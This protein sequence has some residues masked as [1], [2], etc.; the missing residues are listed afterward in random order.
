[1]T[2]APPVARISQWLKRERLIVLVPALF[3]SLYLV[4]LR[5][6]F[7]QDGWLALVA[8][9]EVAERGLPD[10]ERLTAYA[11]GARWVDQQWLAQLCMYELHSL[12]GMPLL[13]LTHVALATAVSAIA[14]TV[15]R[16]S[17]A[18][19]GMVLAVALVAFVPLSFVLATVRTQIFG[20]VA[21]AVVLALLVR[22]ARRPSGRVWAVLP[23]LAVWTNL[24]GSVL[25]GAALVGL[26]GLTIAASDR[27]HVRR[28]VGL[29][30]GAVVALLASPY[31]L[32]L[33]AYYRHTA[34]NPLFAKFVAEWG[35]ATP[36]LSTAPFYVVLLTCAWAYGRRPGALTAYEWL[37]LAV[38]GAAGM[39]TV[40]NAGW[41]ALAAIMILPTVFRA[42][43]R[44]GRAGA[45]LLVVVIPVTLF[46]VLAVIAVLRM[47]DWV[48]AAYPSGPARA[49]ERIALHDG[50]ARVFADVRFA[51]WLLWRDPQL[52]GR[53]AFDAR[54]ELLTGDQIRLIRRFNIQQRPTWERA[55]AGYRIVVL[56]EDRKEPIARALL[57][58]PGANLAYADDDTTVITLDR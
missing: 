9:R 34:F 3:G 25:L 48:D 37:V 11:H 17:G 8:G 24:H 31:V 2:P 13:A 50:G 18:P 10:R 7:S 44:S 43:D 42:S 4:L 53:V 28:G 38:T 40:R 29:I 5:G 35:P 41:F 58:R 21:F 30:V 19:Q 49:V 52:A 23:V 54:Y 12:G 39:A 51:D 1:M 22:D 33:P 20:A 15:A 6:L 32:H 27:G 45:G 56:D 26:R 36:G 46:V 57:A 47:D 55:A 14:V 16:R